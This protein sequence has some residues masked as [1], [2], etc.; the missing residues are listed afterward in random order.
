MKIHM[1][2][3]ALPPRLDGIGDHSA[4]LAAELARSSDVAVLT[5]APAPDPIPGVRVRTAFAAD[6]PASVWGLACP[7][8]QDRP[9]WVLLQYNPFSYGRW[10]WNPHLPRVMRR[11]KRDAPGTRLALMVHEPF[12]PITG[13]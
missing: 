6:D 13:L 9:D 3:A 11:I 12:V 5:G 4:H 8:A 1:I 2:S 10:G 7:V